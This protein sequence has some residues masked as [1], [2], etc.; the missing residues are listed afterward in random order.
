M[1]TASSSRVHGQ[2]SKAA[3]HCYTLQQQCTFHATMAPR[4][5]RIISLLRPSCR[6]LDRTA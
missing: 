6:L 4:N 1:S 5:H 2:G 3:D